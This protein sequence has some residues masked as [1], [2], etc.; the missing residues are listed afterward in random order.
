MDGKLDKLILQGAGLESQLSKDMAHL[1]SVLHDKT[2][3][4]KEISKLQQVV[5]DW[6]TRKDEF[7]AQSGCLRALYFP[8][9]YRRQDDVKQAHEETFKWVMCDPNDNK[10]SGTHV[11]AGRADT[12]SRE[13][14]AFLDWLRSNDA[15]QN[16]FCVFGK[17]GAGK[18]TLMRFIAHHGRLRSALENWAGDRH[19]VIAKYFFWNHGEQLQRSLLGLLRSLLL[20]ILEH[21]RFLVPVAFPD[22]S[23]TIGGDK[24]TFSKDSLMDALKRVLDHTV[25]QS[26]C[27]FIL[28]DGLDEFND[29]EQNINPSSQEVI[30]LEFL[31]MFHD[32]PCLKLCVSTRPY[33]NFKKQYCEGQSRW[34]ALHDLTKSDIKTYAQ[35]RLGKDEKFMKLAV[36]DRNYGSLVDEIVK[37]AEGVFLWVRI[38]CDSL[39]AGITNQDNILDLQLRLRELPS[40]LKKLYRHLLDSVPHE[41]QKNSARSLLVA[42]S[43]SMLRPLVLVQLYLSETERLSSK[44]LE[45]MNFE[46]LRLASIRAKGRV[47]VYTRGLLEVDTDSRWEQLTT[48]VSDFQWYH[49]VLSHRSAGD[50]LK[51]ENIQERLI[52]VA[53][54]RQ[55]PSVHSLRATLAVLRD[56]LRAI[57]SSL[58]PFTTKTSEAIQHRLRGFYYESTDLLEKVSGATPSGFEFENNALEVSEDL[59]ASLWFELSELAFQPIPYFCNTISFIPYGSTYQAT[60]PQTYSPGLALAMIELNTKMCS[61]ELRRMKISINTLYEEPHLL[62]LLAPKGYNILSTLVNSGLDLTVTYKHT[63]STL[64][65]S[66]LWDSV[67]VAFGRVE[68][69][70]KLVIEMIRHGASIDFTCHFAFAAYLNSPGRPH[71]HYLEV[72]HKDTANFCHP[73]ASGENAFPSCP[74]YQRTREHGRV[75]LS[76]GLVYSY[77]PKRS[78]DLKLLEE[79]AFTGAEL[80]RTL[81]DSC[82][83]LPEDEVQSQALPPDVDRLLPPSLG[84]GETPSEVFARLSRDYQGL[85]WNIAIW[86]A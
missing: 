84:T 29:Q 53:N 33:Q 57:Q 67:P 13:G 21:H 6:V 58:A 10:D 60:G 54:F 22:Q 16:V 4:S 35:E 81:F 43:H 23:W 8:E 40:D 79:R 46:Y 9:I 86:E 52:R 14:H 74:P 47:A 45:R 24:F 39:R 44:N 49:T 62:W 12:P 71:R 5:S 83:H 75:R 68:D 41:Y 72:L 34:L 85:R 42:M 56:F 32:R 28:I 38:A 26:L 51:E 18:S 82:C 1:K 70:R 59:V 7:D 64:L 15:H 37:A 55:A 27:F 76:N 2:D 25:N 19:I 20:Q 77:N 78:W 30:L 17:P 11:L 31:K 69:L 48:D 50:F 80:V 65:R 3:T 36:D 66:L 73:G 63:G 61:I